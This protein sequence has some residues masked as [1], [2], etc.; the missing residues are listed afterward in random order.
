MQTKRLFDG[1]VRVGHQNR[2]VGV[3][4]IVYGAAGGHWHSGN[5]ANVE[6]LALE[7]ADPTAISALIT[8][9][10]DTHGSILTCY[11]MSS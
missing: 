11:A 6:I 5:A 9:S 8:L 1:A 3:A 2:H 7:V 10:R 4:F